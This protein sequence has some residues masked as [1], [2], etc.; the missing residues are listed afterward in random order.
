MMSVGEGWKREIRENDERGEGWKRGMRGRMREKNEWEG[1]ERGRVE[2]EN[3]AWLTLLF[4]PALFP[5]DLSVPFD[6][7][8]TLFSVPCINHCSLATLMDSVLCSLA[9]F[10]VFL[11]QDVSNIWYILLYWCMKL[12]TV[13]WQIHCSCITELVMST[14]SLSALRKITYFQTSQAFQTLELIPCGFTTSQIKPVA[15]LRVRIHLARGLA[16]QCSNVIYNVICIQSS[17]IKSFYITSR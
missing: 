9:S 11:L 7:S 8:I 14:I 6:P 5:G 15:D 3:L 2:R 17:Y 16:L 12:E 13:D 10:S 4:T 1:W